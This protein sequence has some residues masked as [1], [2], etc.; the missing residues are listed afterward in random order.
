MTHLEIHDSSTLPIPS[1]MNRA[2]RQTGQGPVGAGGLSFAFGRRVVSRHA[3]RANR[4]IALCTVFLATASGA[5]SYLFVD[6]PP[7]R[8]RQLPYFQC[9]TSKAWPVVDT[10]VA[11]AYA[12]DTAVFLGMAGKSSSDRAA[13]GTLGI[14]SLAAA[15][16]F[17]AS[18]VSGYGKVSDCREATE[19]LQLR[20]M[21]MQPGP[22]AGPWQP[23]GLSPYPPSKPQDPWVTP[24]AQP[25]GTPPANPNPPPDLVPGEKR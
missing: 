15:A 7:E 5:C 23:P 25:F 16:L 6:A 22:G 20:L 2:R 1:S 13:A 4:L 3:P 8:H 21:R 9:T 24:P 10:V 18:A 14:G 17:A 19:E 11:S 12:I